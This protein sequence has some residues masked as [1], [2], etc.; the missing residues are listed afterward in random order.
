MCTQILWSF[1]PCLRKLDAQ[2]TVPGS[3]CGPAILVLFEYKNAYSEM[4]QIYVCQWRMIYLLNPLTPNIFI[5]WK[6]LMWMLKARPN[7]HINFKAYMGSHKA[8]FT[9]G[10]DIK[11]SYQFSGILTSHDM[12]KVSLK[13]VRLQ[14]FVLEIN[15][16]Q[17]VYGNLHMHVWICS[18]SQS[19]PVADSNSVSVV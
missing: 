17:D 4:Y 7:C 6:S 18:C 14:L 16:E 2:Y 19:A 15:E 5:E 1:Q 9:V 11:N 12:Y 13:S 3:G 10:S 8:R